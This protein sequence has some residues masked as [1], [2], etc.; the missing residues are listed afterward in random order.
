MPDSR[1]PKSILFGWLSERCPRCGPRRQWRDV[2]SQ[3]LTQIGV[4]ET[5][6][7][8]KARS[9]RAGWRALINNRIYVYDDEGE[10]VSSKVVIL[11]QRHF[12][13]E[14]DKKRHK[15]CGSACE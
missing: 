9:S 1:L 2:V 3:D 7:Y 10:I 6:W 13:R 12:S 14:S 5:E 11:C 8:D 15:V 4:G